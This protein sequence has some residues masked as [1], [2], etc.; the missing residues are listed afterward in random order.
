ME[1]KQLDT[2]NKNNKTKIDNNKPNKPN[3]EMNQETTQMQ[4]IDDINFTVINSNYTSKVKTIY[5]ISDIHIHLYKRHKEYKLQF[6]K[7]YTYLE[8]E[9]VKKSITSNKDIECIIAITGD[10]LHSKSDL[11]PECIDL[12]YNFIKRL[13]ELMPVIIIPGNHDLNMN[14][15][16]RLDSISPILADLPATHPI[17]YLQK[18]G[19]YL[20]SNLLIMHAS[21]FDY[22]IIPANKLNDIIDYNINNGTLKLTEK[23][24]SNLKT[25]ALYHGR[26]NGCELFNG[27]RLE[28]ESSSIGSNKK[29]VT[30]NDFEGYDIGLCG[31]I[32]L[33]Q[34]ILEKGNVAYAGSM[35]QQNLGEKLDGHG[36]LKWSLK[37]CTYKF[38]EL[39]N[40]YGYVT[41]YIVDGKLK[42][43]GI[44]DK[45]PS[46]IRIRFLYSNSTQSEIDKIVFKIK[47][48]HNILEYNIQ[49]SATVQM[50]S[51]SNYTDETMNV[52]KK[53]VNIQNVDYQ[54]ELLEEIIKTEIDGVEQVEIDEIKELN[55]EVNKLV[56]TE[57]EIKNNSYNENNLQ[58]NRYKFVSLEFSNLYSYG[59]N[60]YIKFIELNGVVGIVAPNHMGKS[61]IIDILLYGL[62]DKFPRKGTIK[63][64]LNIRKDNYKLRLIV[65]CGYYEYIIEKSGERS[66]SGNM[67]KAKCEFMRRNTITG[68]IINLAKDT[69]KSTR[70]YISQYFGHYEDV[71]NTNFSIQTNST[72]F[73]DAENSVRRKELERIMRF[74]YIELLA[75]KINE[76][77]RDCKTVVSHLQSTMP[78]EKIKE[79]MNDISMYEKNIEDNTDLLKKYEGELLQFQEEINSLNQKVNL[80]ID[81]QI[82]LCLKTLEC[83]DINKLSLESIDNKLAEVKS[84]LDI[85]L[86]D[87]DDCI[88]KFKKLCKKGII[89]RLD[90]PN[91]DD[92]LDFCENVTIINFLDYNKLIKSFI[93]EYKKWDKSQNIE[94]QIKLKSLNKQI[95]TFEKDIKPYINNNVKNII[96]TYD[97]IDASNSNASNSNASNSNASNFNAS[98]DNTLNNDTSNGV[99][100]NKDIIKVK[101]LELIDS[102]KN[103]INLKKIELEEF[104]KIDK[105]IKSSNKKIVKLDTS[106]KEFETS[107]LD[108]VNNKMPTEIMSRLKEYNT[109]IKPDKY[110]DVNFTAKCDECI[111][112]LNSP[113]STLPDIKSKITDNITEIKAIYNYEIDNGFMLWVKSYITEDET[114]DDTIKTI[115]DKITNEQK[116]KDKYKKKID[117]LSQSLIKKRDVELAIDKLKATI[118]KIEKDLEAYDYNV[119]L[120]NKIVELESVKSQIEDEL[121]TGSNEITDYIDSVESLLS[122]ITDN[123][124]NKKDYELEISSLEKVSSGLDV[125]LEQLEENTKIQESIL[126][127]TDKRNAV[128][129]TFNKLNKDTQTLRDKYSSNKG[130]LEKMKEDCKIKIEKER[131]LELLD[132]Y[133]M[134]IKFIPMILINKIKPILSRKVNDLLTVVTNF[135]L[136]FNF[137]DNKIDIYLSRSAYNNKNIIINNASG[138]ERF[139]SSI[140]IRLALMEISKLPSPTIMIIDEG[141]S[142]FDTENLN[143]MDVILDHL[144]QRFDYILTISHLQ[145]IRQHC[146]YQIGLVKDD[147]GFS[148]VNFG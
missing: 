92:I 85:L 111:S 110:N 148:K 23:E 76:N 55:K 81:S 83:D 77:I 45:L 79:V 115:K 99:N 33:Q 6:D 57:L 7:L 18:S 49:N 121:A 36:I 16:N 101:V 93:K 68:E 132:I 130:Q 131:M 46:N 106:I 56:Q 147:N 44:L 78:P 1:T 73:I 54:N 26:V 4:S 134:A 35:I 144:K 51:C 39:K 40:E 30:P 95:R 69:I 17:Y 97:S 145:T 8:K 9:K 43:D 48:S 112:M 108:L 133:K 62:F 123:V 3:K 139:I 116:K 86:K 5:H 50:S 126:L 67:G 47:E 105:D 104:S 38:K 32:H 119:E 125:L 11:S 129:D 117:E 146:D 137:D 58:G 52:V 89:Q 100:S 37:T 72:G 127:L 21:I 96:D 28:G 90:V 98:N 70:E 2:N 64:I 94:K 29:T 88:S 63:D 14:N 20:Y 128:L 120:K 75:K 141:W 22:N 143:N 34:N 53:E 61:A 114:I 74:D 19:V 65:S 71:I 142:C 60:N 107:I 27:I 91:K 25:V 118:T 42:D 59:S 140:A 24:R 80:D 13:S 138:F 66:K 10:L 102:I 84:N 124:I 41:L 135:T 109:S 136:E 87:T 15:K 82:D 103:D 113:Q 122:T 12:T 31:D